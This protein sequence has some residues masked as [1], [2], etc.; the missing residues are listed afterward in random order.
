MADSTNKGGE[1]VPDGIRAEAEAGNITGWITFSDGEEVG[2]PVRAV[3]NYIAHVGGGLLGSDVLEESQMGG[4]LVRLDV[5]LEA[6]DGGSAFAFEEGTNVPIALGNALGNARDGLRADI[7]YYVLFGNDESGEPTSEP[8]DAELWSCHADALQTGRPDAWLIE[9]VDLT[10][11]DGTP[12]TADSPALA[13]TLEDGTEV[14][15]TLA[16]FGLDPASLVA[17]YDTAADKRV[18][19]GDLLS[20]LLILRASVG[21]A[22]Q[23]RE[24]REKAAED[25]PLAQYARTEVFQNHDFSAKAIDGLF[26]IAMGE[27]SFELSP[28]SG[29][30]RERCNLTASE[31]A[32]AKLFQVRG[33]NT[34]QVRAI[35]DTVYSLKKNPRAAEFAHE[36]RVWFTVN[37]IAEELLRTDA[38]TIHA[39][40][41][42]TVRGLVDAALEAASGAQMK[43][44]SPDG[45]TT[46]VLY[47]LDAV[48]LDKVTYN[49]ETYSDVWGIAVSAE[50]LSEY[51]EAKGH[52]YHYALPKRAKPFTLDTV[53]V[54]SYLSRAM[55][56]ARSRL[57][58]RSKT[59]RIGRKRGTN[60]VLLKRSWQGGEHSIFALASPTRA[61]SSRQKDRVVRAFEDELT[62]IVREESHG[63]RREGMPLYVRAWSERDGGRGR[64][65]GAYRTLCLEVSTTFRAVRDGE[66]GHGAVNLR[67]GISKAAP[68]NAPE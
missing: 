7:P 41:Y 47:L 14:S 1:R 54:N 9:E 17:F 8:L 64:G 33:A 23:L 18:T 55:N 5:H 34:E 30:S 12:A 4:G 49:G 27:P 19:L 67:D 39:K 56:E 6:I 58:T 46:K 57:Y 2:V 51:A 53:W 62:N 68:D 45:A 60:T 61:L 37:H 11:G 48:R 10:L 65:K 42:P 52:A 15:H 63:E 13:E 28:R 36:G 66:N 26:N 31:D 20:G 25:V 24:R 16:E 3:A 44:I 21:V 50:T 35:L 29:K 22:A 40:D 38:G 43:V 32:C 59:G